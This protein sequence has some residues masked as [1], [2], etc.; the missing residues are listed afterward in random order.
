MDQSIQKVITTLMKKLP[1]G[2]TV[3]VINISSS[4]NTVS[5]VVLNEVVWSVGAGRCQCWG[6]SAQDPSRVVWSGGSVGR[7]PN[8]EL[9]S[10]YA[11][12][13]WNRLRNAGSSLTISRRRRDALS[14]RVNIDLDSRQER[15]EQRSCFFLRGRG[16]PCGASPCSRNAH[17]AHCRSWRIDSGVWFACASIAVLY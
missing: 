4:D 1:K 3:A 13:A 9:K 7:S 5:S 15:C 11:G 16:G 17:Y 6:G 8:K 12:P 10:P 14:G 2:A